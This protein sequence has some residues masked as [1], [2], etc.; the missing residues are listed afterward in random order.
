MQYLIIL[1]FMIIQILN[2][3][4]IGINDSFL[5]EIKPKFSLD[6]IYTFII[7]LKLW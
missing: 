7:Y 1:F 6:I 3:W 5:S 2:F 4:I